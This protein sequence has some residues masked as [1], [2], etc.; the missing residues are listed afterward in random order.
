MPDT[1]TTN[2]VIAGI[3]GQGSVLAAKIL[4]Q[5]AQTKG[6]T[7]RT[8][9]TIG[10]AQR[11]GSVT[12]HVR[13]SAA[14]RVEA[15]LVA[16]GQAQL[17]IALEPGEGVRALP[18]LAPEG[19]LVS[20][21]SVTPAVM[22]NLAG[23]VYE[24]QPMLAQ[25]TAY[26][27][28]FLSVDEEAV[29]REVGSRKVANVALLAAAVLACQ[30]TGWG[31]GSAIDLNDMIAA[32]K[33]CVKPRFIDVNMAAVAAVKKQLEAAGAFANNAAPLS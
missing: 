26:A 6:W 16:R 17:V 33:E 7:V 31:F 4:A 11:G 12:S 9:E 5:A 18:F 23:K 20:A 14:G 32:L 25:L 29:C 28:H 22:A 10:M 3:G 2:I 13:M 30:E 1:Q 24:A 15:P 8:A 27:P 19:L 21:T